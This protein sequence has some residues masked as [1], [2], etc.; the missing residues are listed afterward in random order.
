MV[1]G[2]QAV[3]LG[4]GTFADN[5]GEFF[6][7]DAFEVFAAA[8]KCLKCSDQSLSH[9]AMR[10]FGTAHNCKVLGTGHPLV[11]VL[12]IEA[13]AEEVSLLVGRIVHEYR[14][15]DAKRVVLFLG[16]LAANVGKRLILLNPDFS[17]AGQFQNGKE[18][19]HNGCQRGR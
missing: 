2:C 18:G 9:S 7:L 14:L 15:S 12:V 1:R 19:G 13:N 4:G 17:Q 5:I 6:L 11:T 10:F 3:G 8:I 16:P